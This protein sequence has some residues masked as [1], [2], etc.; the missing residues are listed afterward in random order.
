PPKNSLYDRRWGTAPSPTIKEALSALGMPAAL[1]DYHIGWSRALGFIPA[2]RP[3]MWRVFNELPEH[4]PRHR[5]GSG[6]TAR[7]TG[8]VESLEQHGRDIHGGPRRDGGRPRWP[9][10]Q[11]AVRL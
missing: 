10:G 3:D 7:W 4:D 8:R 6:T 11:G 2:D 5:F 9:K 1:T